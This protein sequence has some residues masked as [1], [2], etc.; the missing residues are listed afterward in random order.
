MTVR[1]TARPR[2]PLI[3][4]HDGEVPLEIVRCDGS[5]VDVAHLRKIRLCRCGASAH[6][7]MCDGSHDRIGFEAQGLDDER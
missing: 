4:E 5:R 3:V 2:G 7:P 1:I 6:A